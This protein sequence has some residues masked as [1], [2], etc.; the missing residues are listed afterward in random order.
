MSTHTGN[1]LKNL[2]LYFIRKEKGT[3]YD[4]LCMVHS[5]RHCCN[6]DI[7]EENGTNF[8][9]YCLGR[10]CFIQIVKRSPS[11]VCVCVWGG[12]GGGG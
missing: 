11:R 12:G 7:A 9:T 2:K 6:I 3:I 1:Q 8:E 4:S 5:R 10:K